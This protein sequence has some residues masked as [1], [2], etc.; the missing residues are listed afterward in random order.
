MFDF[1]QLILSLNLLVTFLPPDDENDF[2][3]A[4]DDSL[5]HPI[6]AYRGIHFFLAAKDGVKTIKNL[7]S[8]NVSRRALY[9]LFSF[10]RLR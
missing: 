2:L 9:D 8:A 10:V 6:Q 1:F 5:C 7:F 4:Y 3:L